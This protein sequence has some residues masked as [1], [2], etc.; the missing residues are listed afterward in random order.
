MTVLGTE[1]RSGS[2]ALLK[3]FISTHQNGLL[4][5]A[6]PLMARFS[7]SVKGTSC[8][9][10]SKITAYPLVRLVQLIDPDRLGTMPESDIDPVNEGREMNVPCQTVHLFFMVKY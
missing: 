10:L 1:R 8:E 2:C 6:V 9:I 4:I 3:I 7:E 5:T